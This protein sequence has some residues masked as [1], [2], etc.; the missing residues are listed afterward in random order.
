MGPHPAFLGQLPDAQIAGHGRGQLRPRLLVSGIP[1]PLSGELNNLVLNNFGF[2]DR[3]MLENH[4][5]GLPAKDHG[6]CKT[7]PG[8]EPGGGV[9]VGASA[10]MGAE[11]AVFEPGGE[12]PKA[13]PQ[14]NLPVDV[15][16]VLVGVGG[17]PGLKAW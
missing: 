9:S 13:K 8:A 4:V 3:R 7:Q 1:S 12:K 16:V 14:A 6:P 5:A 15:I 10:S 2:T 17:G 11:V